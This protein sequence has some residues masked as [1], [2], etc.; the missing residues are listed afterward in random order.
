MSFP[1]NHPQTIYFS[2]KNWRD[3]TAVENSC[4]VVKGNRWT[5]SMARD[6]AYLINYQPISYRVVD[7][8]SKFNNN[9]NSDCV[10]FL[11][12]LQACARFAADVTDRLRRS[13]FSPVVTLEI[14]ADYHASLSLHC[15]QLLHYSFG[16]HFAFH[17][18]SLR[19]LKVVRSILGLKYEAHC[20]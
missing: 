8:R 4:Q 10:L 3:H 15:V 1:V 13:L 18:I 2:I 12:W 5:C 16:K 11:S 14:L 20:V 7:V 9:H 17:F 6:Q 19:I